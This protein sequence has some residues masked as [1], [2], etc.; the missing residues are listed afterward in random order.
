MIDTVIHGSPASCRSLA[1]QLDRFARTVDQQVSALTSARGNLHTAWS[2]LAADAAIARLTKIRDSAATLGRRS[3]ILASALPT[4]ATALDDVRTAIDGARAA[5]LAAGLRVTADGIFLPPSTAAPDDPA[6]QQTEAGRERAFRAAAQAVAAARRAEAAAHAA[7]LNA[8]A[9]VDGDDPFTWFLEKLG[10]ITPG[11][12]VDDVGW[13]LAGGL[14]TGFGVWADWRRRLGLGHFAPRGPDG[15]FVRVHKDAWWRHAM[16]APDDRNWKARPYRA[17]SYHAT[18]TAA[19]WVG[20]A[21][22][23]VA[24][25]AA[26][27]QQWEQ[28]A[29]DPALG[30]AERV[31]RA[32]TQGVATGAGAWAGAA[33]GVKGGAVV[34]MAIGGPVGAVVGGAIGGLVGGA[35]GSSVGQAAGDAIKDWAGDATQVVAAAA[36]DAWDSIADVGGDALAAAGDGLAN[37]GDALTFWD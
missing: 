31:G 11:T 23:V 35:I 10:I 24:V 9:V 3:N 7:L 25:G 6:A 13:W 29:D 1:D 2:G 32:A 15:R 12:D 18:G 4:F 5:A 36:S 17:D 34:G 21:G 14:G 19:R 8:V 28:D 27:W 30:D 26:A 22:T 33:V 37:F 20:R 16:Q